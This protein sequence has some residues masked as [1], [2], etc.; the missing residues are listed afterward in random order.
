M[1]AAVPPAAEPTGDS[2]AAVEEKVRSVL[3]GRTTLFLS[4]AAHDAP[5]AAGTF[6][7]EAGLFELGIVL[8]T[9]GT[10]LANLRANPRVAVVVSSGSPFEPFLQEEGTAAEL[11]DAREVEATTAALLAKAPEI[12]PFLRAPLVAV[13]LRL[14]RWRATDVP[15]GWF[16]GKELLAEGRPARGP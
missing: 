11:T 15:N 6:F 10:T 16:P 8:E 13:A 4:T 12:A 5:W 7:A 9:R 14:R 2:P 3:A 1:T